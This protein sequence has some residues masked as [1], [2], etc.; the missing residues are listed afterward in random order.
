[1]GKVQPSID[2]RDAFAVAYMGEAKMNGTLAATIAGFSPDSA[3]IKASQ[4]LDESEVIAKID[5]IKAKRRAEQETRARE[6][7]E[8]LFE[9]AMGRTIATV[10]VSEGSPIM[11]EPKHADRLR[12]G[13]LFLKMNGSLIDKLEVTTTPATSEALRRAADE[14]ARVEQLEAQLR[15]R[16]GE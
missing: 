11:G 10:G 6:I 13:E 4:L 15:E 14:R 12:A 3:H 5:A 16:G 1:V 8:M 7:G 9:T 2:R